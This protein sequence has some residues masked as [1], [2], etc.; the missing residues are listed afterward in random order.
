MPDGQILLIVNGTVESDDGGVIRAM[1]VRLTEVTTHLDR[2]ETQTASRRFVEAQELAALR[3]DLTA[4][5][6]QLADML[7]MKD[8]VVVEQAAIQ[9]VA[10]AIRQETTRIRGMVP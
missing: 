9:E 10:D 7:M 3:A 1:L 6:T 5:S 8:V 2:L 4:M